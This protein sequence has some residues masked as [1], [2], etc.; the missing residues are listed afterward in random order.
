MQESRAL[1]EEA[2]GVSTR[3]AWL[4]WSVCGLTLALV[5][6]AL[7]LAILNDADAAAVSFPFAMTASAVVG[8]LV[9]SRR[10]KNPVG[11]FFLGS[12]ACF[13]LVGFAN[14]YAT[15]GLLTAPG[16][17][18]GAQA[19][20]W[21]LSWL[22]VPGVTL[23]LSFVPL[24]F[25]DGRLVSR[26]WRWVVR[27]ALFFSVTGAIFAA[28]RPG[29]IQNEGI[30]NPLG[31]EALRAILGLLDTLTFAL[32]FTLLFASAAS[33]VVRFRRSGPTEREQIKWLALAALAIPVWFLTNAQ[34]EAAAPTLFLVIDSLLFAGIPVAAGIA[35][36]KYR[37][38]DVDVVI[39]RTLV[40]GSLTASL[41]LVYF[42]GVTAIQA[43]F[44]AL[45][46]Q[47]SQLAVVASTLAIAAL[48][49]PLRRRVQ[50]FVD[51][52]FY[53]RKYDA[54][55]TLEAFGARLR[56][57]TDLDA[58]NEE[59]VAVVRETLQPAHVSLWLR[60]APESGGDEESGEPRG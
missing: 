36:L 7:A 32:Y 28:F 23:L 27:L 49:N 1:G 38:Y 50:A 33:L 41:A 58:L 25:P 42:G 17:L 43:I 39:N 29:E 51:R 14:G 21:P 52:R 47:E 34:I 30:V 13:A 9:A 45:T 40:Y 59:L 8:G 11:W 6:C 26:R 60:P 56:N 10:P 2:G 12:G 31:I 24:Y 18:P 57:E 15:Y 37:L 20:A 55:K 35:I 53:R 4:A 44:R 22:W 54:A 16:A 3:A 19:M 48:F 46:G 5:A